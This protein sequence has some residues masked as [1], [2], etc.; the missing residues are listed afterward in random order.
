MNIALTGLDYGIIAA[1]FGV[2]AGLC[3]FKV[4]AK[5]GA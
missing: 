4:M 3:W 5:R 1:V 2:L